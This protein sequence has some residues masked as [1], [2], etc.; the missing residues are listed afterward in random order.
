M[1]RTGL[2]LS[3]V[4]ISALFSCSKENPIAPSA[5]NEL[6]I[7]KKDGSS[8]VSNRSILGYWTLAISA[9]RE[10][11][12]AIP[13]RTAAFHLNAVNLLENK[14]CKN[15]LM[16]SNLVKLPDNIL[17]IDVTLR[18]P[19]PGLD[20]FTAFDV[21]GILISGSDYEFPVSGK[22]I[23]WS[24]TYLR[25]IGPDGYTSL[26]NPTEFPESL[27]VLPVFKYMKGKFALGDDLGSTLNPFVS[28]GAGNERQMFN[29]GTEET[30]TLFLKLPPGPIE[31]GY[32]IDA[33]WVPVDGPVTDPA[34][35]FPISANCNEAYELRVESEPGL[36]N[37]VPISVEV[38]DHQGLDTIESVTM[39]A[40][41]LFTGERILTFQETT[42]SGGFLF[43]G[44]LNNE[45]VTPNGEYPVLVRV[46]DTET[47]PILGTNEAWTIYNAVVGIKKGWAKTWGDIG[48]DYSYGVATDS[49][50]YIYTSGFFWGTVDFD[51]GPGI[52]KH[53]CDPPQYY[54]TNAY[55]SK[56]DSNGNFLWARTWGG[57]DFDF[58]YSVTTDAFMNIYVTGEFYGVSDFDPGPGEDWHEGKWGDVFLSK[59]DSNGNFI[60][61]RTWGGNYE[62]AGF[63]TKTDYLG[64]IYIGGYFENTV[65]F[66]PGPGEDNHSSSGPFPYQDPDAFLSKFDPD[67]N[68]IWARTWGGSNDDFAYGITIDQAGI[69]VT[70]LFSD[71]MVDFDPGPN[72]DQH[73]TEG[74]CDVF[75]SKFDLDGSHI[76]AE[77]WGGGGSDQGL[78]VVVAVDSVYVVGDF[79]GQVDFSPGMGALIRFSNGESDAFLSKFN[80]DGVPYS[81][82]TWGGT[83][84][85]FA[86][87]VTMDSA[88][89][90]YVS[91]SF[92]NVV[93][94]DPT[95]GVD[96]HVS[97]G[98]YDIF[99]TKFDSD[100]GYLWT[101]TWGG[102]DT[103]DDWT[104]I[105]WDLATDPSDNIYITGWF[106]GKVDFDP[107]YGVDQH[108]AKGGS[109]CFLSKFPPDGNW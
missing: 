66:D 71:K 19:F 59:F 36:V 25:M 10:N 88:G 26:F 23:S 15:C 103:T 21:R 96:I 65:D 74:S 24:G 77:T 108:Y 35:D 95:N 20:N 89:D 22:K 47:D 62:E 83:G 55:L 28:Y 31:F 82:R 93:D 61:A 7:F 14:A 2:V 18:H 45:L 9:D 99:L 107:G 68:F 60:W 32:A 104:D 91:G 38:F 67:G 11:V 70:G 100:M 73:S 98:G 78:G 51:P 58:A 50:G 90:V 1:N 33:C 30:R 63:S 64:N 52:D 101:H 105:G 56:F 5:Q 27:P 102:N 81:A 84:E 94:L 80:K 42:S 34:N 3:V 39:E 49:S 13:V 87:A 4:I 69:Y 57:T 44:D 109:D 92:E 8:T 53:S 79:E 48:W 106:S 43:V 46:L 76:W 37:S 54:N 16:I 86:S 6:K 97:F 29:A 72:N 40:P 12:T 85:D 75:L 17:S 41:D